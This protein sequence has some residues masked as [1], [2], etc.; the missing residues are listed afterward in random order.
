MALK[1]PGKFK[2]CPAYFAHW[3][4]STNRLIEIP[5]G[6]GPG[7]EWNVNEVPVATLFAEAKWMWD[8]DTAKGVKERLSTKAYQHLGTYGVFEE[9]NR[10][11]G[12][13]SEKVEKGG[14]KMLASCV[15][16]FRTY[17][18]SLKSDKG[19]DSSFVDA[20]HTQGSQR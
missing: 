19:D 2:N 9:Q 4:V 14:K 10:Y 8:E 5:K 11:G 18:K 15:K 1:N 20:D 16:Y 12:D 13:F 3:S 6:L 17:W 7:V